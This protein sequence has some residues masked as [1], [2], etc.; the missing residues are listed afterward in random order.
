MDSINSSEP[1]I[2]ISG[3]LVNRETVFFG[4]GSKKPDVVFVTEGSKKQI[5]KDVLTPD[6]SCFDSY[7]SSDF[8]VS[9]LKECEINE[10]YITGAMKDVFETED[11][12]HMILKLEIEILR[13]KLVV[14]LGRKSEKMLLKVKDISPG[15]RWFEV[16]PHPSFWLTFYSNEKNE[17]VNLLRDIKRK[18]CAKY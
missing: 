16:L 13:P 15:F 12:N 18:V 6:V 10:Y 1:K 11:E 2:T 8:F 5:A 7:Q 17:Y 4:I 3:K 14:A 9:C